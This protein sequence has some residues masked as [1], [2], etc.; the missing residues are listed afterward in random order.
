MKKKIAFVTGPMIMGGIEKALITLLENIQTD[1][2]DVTVY[3]TSKNGALVSFLPSYVKV[4]C[5][6]G[7]EESLREMMWNRMKKGKFLSAFTVSFNTWRISKTKSRFEQDRLYSRMLPIDK[8]TFD[9]AIAYYSPVTLPVIYTIKNIKAKKKIAW[10]H[11]DVYFFEELLRKYER[12]YRKFDQIQCVS[13]YVRQRFL[14][15]FPYFHSKT[16]VFY[17]MTDRQKIIKQGNEGEGFS[18]SFTGFRIVTVGRVAKEKGQDIIPPVLAKLKEEGFTVRW[19]VI[20]DGHLKKELE[21]MIQQYRLENHLF[22]LGEKNNPYPFIKDCDLYVQPSRHESYC[23][24]VAEARIFHRPI[25][26]TNTGAREQIRNGET[27]VIVD[28]DEEALVDG[29]R[30]LLT[31]KKLREKLEQ[32][33]MLEMVDTSG[34]INKFDTLT[35]FAS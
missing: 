10:I 3:V 27:G 24:S 18:D 29:I 22:L 11:S 14:Q 31:D 23:I 32:N 2:Y 12:Y 34:E 15:I 30:R 13:D 17:N 21:E 7:P 28:F 8:E 25:V 20:G 1:K 6:F 19:Y 33:L 35:D 9:V 16:S 5:I 26:I 4:K